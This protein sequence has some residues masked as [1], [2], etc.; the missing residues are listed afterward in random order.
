MTELLFYKDPYLREFDA[1]VVD[2]F[3]HEGRPVVV[4]D[5]T[6]FYATSGGQPHDT[7]TLGGVQVLEVVERQGRVW[8]FLDRP[9]QGDVRGVI[10]WA[11]RVDHM[12][13]HHGQHILSEAFIQVARAPTL[14]FHLGREGCSIDL[15]R[16][17][18]PSEID[19]AQ[20]LANQVIFENRPVSIGWFTLDQVRSMNVR[21][22]DPEIR[23]PIRIVRVEGFDVQPCSG[24]HPSST[25]QVGGVAVLALERLKEGARV[26]F[27]C[28]GRI[29]AAAVRLSRLARSLSSKL[30]APAEE[31][32]AAVD[33]RL[34]EEQSMRRELAEATR[35]LSRYRAKEIF[36][37]GVLSGG[38]R[39]CH[40][41]EP[42]RDL[43]ALKGLA[44]EILANGPCRA[45][46]LSTGGTG[47]FFIVAASPDQEVDLRPWLKEWLERF[48]GKGGGEPRFVQGSFASTDAAAIR[49]ALVDRLRS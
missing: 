49:Q 10:D 43:K 4:L 21:K 34:L 23:E 6:A 5:R 8:H 48:G 22:L 12:Q 29:A 11:R 15:A 42:G 3:A 2:S 28:G 9:V 17:P 40:D 46:L 33:R 39:I 31:L 18:S 44:Q 35:R 7:G 27:V 1:R 37:S 32:E 45:A 47:T 14:S 36:D 24:T 19:E 26:S 16:T 41:A 20:A 25:G 38:R 13:Q 30:S